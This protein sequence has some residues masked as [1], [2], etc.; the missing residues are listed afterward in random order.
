MIVHAVHMAIVLYDRDLLNMS[1]PGISGGN[2]AL[3]TSIDST[4]QQSTL[5]SFPKCFRRINFASLIKMYT[6]KF[7]CTDPR[8][9]LQYYFF[10]RN[11]PTEVTIKSDENNTKRPSTIFAQYICE[12]A[13]ETREFDLL[14]GKLEKSSVR[15][16]GAIDRF[17]NDEQVIAIIEQVGDEIESRG[18]IEEAIKLYDL[19]QQNQRVLELCNKLVSQVVTDVNVANST[20]DRLKTMTTSIA[21]R[22]KN[23]SN[24]QM[25]AIP[26]SVVTTF[27]LLTDLMTF[28]DMY[29]AENW[30]VAYDTMNKLGILPVTSM[31]V[32]AKVKEFITFSE[33]IKRNFPDLLV[34][35]MTI[36]SALFTRINK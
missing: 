16:P 21:H 34:A 27:F 12:L 26:K 36:I 29:H 3:I 33:E 8:E 5:T 25:R 6:R 14:F 4:T 10:L 11:M 1:R 22:Y 20:R 13:F 15:R 24:I 9:A 2:S 18:L 32:E 31:N 28:F 7:E 23:E 17:L 19:C 30:D 35:S